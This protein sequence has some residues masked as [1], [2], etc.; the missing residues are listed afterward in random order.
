MYSKTLR[1]VHA[2]FSFTIRILYFICNYKALEYKDSLNLKMK[3]ECAVVGPLIRKSSL[4]HL[5]IYFAH[6]VFSNLGYCIIATV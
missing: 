6:I 3:L 4:Q 2:G 5:T 1:E